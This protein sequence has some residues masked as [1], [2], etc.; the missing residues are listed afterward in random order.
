[1]NTNQPHPPPGGRLNPFELAVWETCKIVD[2]WTDVG[3]AKMPVIPTRLRLANREHVFIPE[4]AGEVRYWGAP[5]DGTYRRADYTDAIGIS[6]M[7]DVKYAQFGLALTNHW[8]EKRARADAQPRWMRRGTPGA[9]ALIITNQRVHVDLGDTHHIDFRY[10]VFTTIDLPGYTTFHVTLPSTTGQQLTY[11]LETVW[12][13]LIFIMAAMRF[14]RSHPLLLNGQWLPSGIEQY[15]ETLG[16]PCPPARQY[17]NQWVQNR[18][19]TPQ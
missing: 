17:A 14:F 1:M 2:A 10:H 15:L 5:G 8:R 9:E 7:N 16:H 19:S 3:T 13:P 12:A 6:S 18:K 11:R 4:S